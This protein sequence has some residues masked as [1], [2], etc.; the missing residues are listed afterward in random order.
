MT[1]ICFHLIIIRTGHVPPAADVGVGSELQFAT[2]PRSL[3]SARS[4][5]SSVLGWDQRKR[6]TD[7]EMAARAAV[8]D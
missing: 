1:A 5:D 8:L 2:A 4:I 6:E 3:R 7:M